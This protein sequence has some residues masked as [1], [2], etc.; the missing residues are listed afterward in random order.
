[1]PGSTYSSCGVDWEVSQRGTHGVVTRPGCTSDAPVQVH[2]LCSAR[3]S[4]EV[5]TMWT[6]CCG[7]RC[8]ALSFRNNSHNW[9]FPSANAAAQIS[10]MCAAL[11]WLLEQA[12]KSTGP[13]QLFNC[14]SL[15][16]SCSPGLDATELWRDLALLVLWLILLLKVILS[17]IC[18][19]FYCLLV[20][21]PLYITAIPE[22]WLIWTSLALP[23]PWEILESLSAHWVAWK[24]KAQTDCFRNKLGVN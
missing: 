3:A 1:M 24:M 2:A 10:P 20:L 11:L 4:R 5:T 18:D 14:W 6:C 23:H 8:L 13:G 21:G 7:C 19:S 16:S 15:T 22:Q 17:L 9:C 12:V